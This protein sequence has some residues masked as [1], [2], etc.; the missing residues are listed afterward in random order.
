MKRIALIFDFDDTLAAD[1]T[2]AYLKSKGV[3]VLK[4]WQESVDKLINSDWDPIPAY[5]YE[6]I[7]LHNENKA[8][9][10]KSSMQEFATNIAF[11]K[12][13]EDFFTNIT[14]WL[15]QENK[16]YKIEFY[17]IS[18]GIGEIVRNTRISKLFKNIWC[19]EF[20]YNRNGDIVFPRKVMS[21]TDKTRYLFQISK[22]IVGEKAY[23]NPFQVN[24]KILSNAYYI[25]FT[26][27]IYIGDGYTD[28]PCFSLLRQNQGHAIAVYD[29]SD[30]QKLEKAWSFREEDR[31]DNLHSADFRDTSDLYATIQMIIKNIIKKVDY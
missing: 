2:S 21:Y 9:I 16:D 4:F 18:S 10:T 17:I 30:K 28:I 29:R 23:S 13:V 27:M 6:M 22:G 25:P 12:G 20:N 24:N 1:S 3:D 15:E 26:Q 5:L 8:Q 7:C 11:H 31:V 19:N 14:N